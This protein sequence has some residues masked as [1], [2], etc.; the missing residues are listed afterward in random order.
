VPRSTGDGVSG[1]SSAGVV[2]G[3]RGE[4][5]LP[6]EPPP[7]PARAS[8]VKDAEDIRKVRRF[9]VHHTNGS[10]LPQTKEGLINA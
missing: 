9:I 6:E 2:T 3:L 10:K 4:L 8:V 1:F 5:L 7:H